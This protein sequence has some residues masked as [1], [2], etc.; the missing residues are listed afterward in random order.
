MKVPPDKAYAY[1]ADLSRHAEW[2]FAADKMT[3]KSDNPGP[4]AVGSAYSAE[5]NL[6][7]RN[8]SKVTITA[9]NPPTSLEFESEDKAGI[10]GHVFEFVAKDGGTLITRKMFG[11]KVPFYG[12]L[13]FLLARG[14]ID[15]DYNG[16]LANLK[17][18]LD[19]GA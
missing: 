5:G 16:A 18:K 13:L 12:P 14:A 15:K 9:L 4:A 8:R 19:S 1:V 6:M 10:N 11:V 7:G 17:T 3:I 2:S